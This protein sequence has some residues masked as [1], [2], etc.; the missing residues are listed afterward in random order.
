M[1]DNPDGENVNMEDM[2]DPVPVVTRTHFEEALSGARTS[3]T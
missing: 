3:V 2:D 1:K